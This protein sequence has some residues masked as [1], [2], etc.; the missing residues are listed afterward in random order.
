MP[1]RLAGSISL[2]AVVAIPVNYTSEF[3]ESFEATK[4]VANV[5]FFLHGM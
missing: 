2:F 4:Y 3:R 5:L 1:I